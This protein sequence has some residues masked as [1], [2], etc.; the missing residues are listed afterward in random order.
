MFAELRE[1]N[2]EALASLRIGP[3]ELALTGM[4]PGLGK[5][6][7]QNLLAAWV[8]HDLG[9]VSQVARALASQYRG[10]VGPWTAYMSI[11]DPPKP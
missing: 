10:E 7:M 9:H 11:L 5:V 3:D 2:I 1:Q 6:T 4:H 8:V